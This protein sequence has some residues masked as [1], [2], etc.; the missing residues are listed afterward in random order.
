MTRVLIVEDDPL[1]A[2]TLRRYLE[3]DQIQA[4]CVFSV[5]AAL[6]AL[7]RTAYDVIV[8]DLH[9]RGFSGIELARRLRRTRLIALTGDVRAAEL[10]GE[11]D[12]VLR[13]PC[14]PDRLVAAITG[15]NE[16]E[17]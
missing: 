3:V 5:E 9:L 10:T 13:K 16:H 6:A 12:L 17:G 11:F 7:G 15:R 2:Q 8:T 14:E 4:D 1:G